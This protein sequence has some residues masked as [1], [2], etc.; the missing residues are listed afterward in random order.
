VKGHLSP[1]PESSL[2]RF[3]A[4]AGAQLRV[5]SHEVFMTQEREYVLGTHDEEIARLGLQHRVWRPRALAAWRSAG[6]RTGQMFI[7]LGCGPGYATLDLAEIA[8]PAGRVVAV[9]RSQRFLNTL[10]T[11]GAARGLDNIEIFESDLDEG[12]LPAVAADGIWVRWVFAFVK[13]PADLLARATKL[14]KPGGKIVVHEYFDY[15]TWRFAPRSD[16]F[17]AFVMT[18][19]KSWRA[20]GGEP[21]IGLDLPRWMGE[22]GLRVTSLRPIVEVIAPS[23]FIWEWPKSF[24]EVSLARLI[25]LGRMTSDEARRVSDEFESRSAAEGTLMIT[26]AVLEIIA[27]KEG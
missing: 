23:S 18:V 6:F 17:E 24:V 16:V 2:L 3:V 20:S 21:D 1:P 5:L 11:A 8:G 10:R 25:D 15:S 13:R 4:N 7:D 14:L 26:P 12:E 22:L 9:D 27:E 19:M